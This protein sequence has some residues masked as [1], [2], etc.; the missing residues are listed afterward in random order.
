MENPKLR[1]ES[2]G[3]ITEVYIDGEKVKYIAS[4]DFHAEIL[5]ATCTIEKRIENEKG[6]IIPDTGKVK[7]ENL[8]FAGKWKSRYCDSTIEAGGIEQCKKE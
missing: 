6:T 4:Y 1:I 3:F 5:K 2:D 8:D 7:I